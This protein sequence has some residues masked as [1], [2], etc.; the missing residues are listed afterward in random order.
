MTPSRTA[1]AYT[2]VPDGVNVIAIGPAQFGPG[3]QQQQLVHTGGNCSVTGFD[4]D[5]QDQYWTV[6]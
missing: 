5:G 3:D 6:R 4:I 2:Q 1:H